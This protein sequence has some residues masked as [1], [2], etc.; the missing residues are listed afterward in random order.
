VLQEK[1]KQRELNLVEDC[2]IVGNFSLPEGAE[3]IVQK[4]RTVT[5][6]VP[7]PASLGADPE[8]FPPADGARD[9]V[10]NFLRG[11]SC[12]LSIQPRRLVALIDAWDC[13]D[14]GDPDLEPLKRDLYFGALAEGLKVKRNK[15]GLPI[16]WLHQYKCKTSWNMKG[17]LVQTLWQNDDPG[18]WNIFLDPKQQLWKFRRNQLA[19]ELEPREEQN[20]FRT[21]SWMDSV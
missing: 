8:A 10:L 21:P 2:D 7:V 20:L 11:D 19:M 5:Y 12:R 6:Q 17:N 1:L 15:D 18:N 3:A 4:G 16:F 9:P 13:F 14:A